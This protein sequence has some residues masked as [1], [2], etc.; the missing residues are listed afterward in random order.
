MNVSC[1]DCS[2]FSSPYFSHPT[3]YPTNYTSHHTYHIHLTS[4]IIYT[5]CILYLYQ[6][7]QSSQ[8]FCYSSLLSSMC[9][10]GFITSHWHDFLTLK[11]VAHLLH[12]NTVALSIHNTRLKIIA[13]NIGIHNTMIDTCIC[14]V[15][16]STLSTCYVC[17]MCL[18]F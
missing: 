16:Y 6:S 9:S 12:N 5:I 8:S 10:I 4:P 2:Y 11:R 18:L 14:I 3:L 13:Y 15:L 7:S 1:Y 17:T